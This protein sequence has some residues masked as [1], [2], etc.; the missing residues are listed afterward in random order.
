MPYLVNKYIK[1]TLLLTLIHV[2]FLATSQ[3]FKLPLIPITL[4]GG[5]G[6]AVIWVL[7]VAAGGM[8]TY[9]AGRASNIANSLVS[10]S[11][12]RF[13]A[14]RSSPGIATMEVPIVRFVS[15]IAPPLVISAHL[16]YVGNEIS[17]GGVWIPIIICLA[18]GITLWTEL[19]VGKKSMERYARRKDN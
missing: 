11:S 16:G 14:L 9:E 2:L 19:P 4:E 18:V 8:A 7:Y 1:F 15:S 3:P 12:S 13:D 5:I 10:L 6:F 17:N